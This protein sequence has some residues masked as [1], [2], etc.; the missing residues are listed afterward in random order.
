MVLWKPVWQF[1][2]KLDTVTVRAP[3]STHSYT[4]WRHENIGAQKTCTHVFTAALS[5]LAEEPRCLPTDAQID[6]Q[7]VCPE[8]GMRVWFMLPYR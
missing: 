3:D 1:F 7:E 6:T 4:G 2:E 8:K 5:T